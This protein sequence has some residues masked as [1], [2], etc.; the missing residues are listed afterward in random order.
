MTERS[1]SFG[2]SSL[3]KPSVPVGELGGNQWSS[4]SQPC[5]NDQ[6]FITAL[7]FKYSLTKNHTAAVFRH[8]LRQEKSIHLQNQT[9]SSLPL[10]VAL[11]PFLV[12]PLLIEGK[13]TLKYA[14]CGTFCFSLS[15]NLLLSVADAQ[16][17]TA[18][19]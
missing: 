10:V 3:S 2:W 12:Y 11:E 1:N 14:P 13:T 19:D 18:P 5:E 17:R 7:I 4:A 8:Q 6:P 15:G 16:R 9:R